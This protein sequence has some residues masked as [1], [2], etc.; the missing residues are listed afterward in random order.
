[1]RVFRADH[2]LLILSASVALMSG[3]MLLDILVGGAELSGSSFSLYDTFISKNDGSVGN[4][5]YL[6]LAYAALPAFCEELIF[7]GIFCAE[8]ERSG[9]VCASLM[10]MLFFAMLHFDFRHFPVYVFSAAV[11]CAVMY[12]TRS[13]PA[14]MAVHFLYNLF[15]LFGVPYLGA[16]YTSTG[17]AWLLVFALIVLFLFGGALFCGEAARMYRGYAMRAVEET[18][19]EKPMGAKESAVKFA[20]WVFTPQAMIAIGLYLI[21]VI[22]QAFR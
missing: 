6:V 2:I 17:G 3:G 1:M 9:A 16:V 10:S 5:V 11:L 19:T 12:A 22:V 4:G 15:G 14:S 21:V 13:L 18:A 20:R 7:R 8:Y